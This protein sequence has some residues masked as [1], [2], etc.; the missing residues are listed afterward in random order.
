MFAFLSVAGNVSVKVAVHKSVCHRLLFL[1]KE[2]VTVGLLEVHA[3][4]KFWYY[5]QIAF[6]EF[7]SIRFPIIFFLIFADV[8]HRK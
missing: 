7:E 1:W 3:L 2:F 8:M 6:Q 5:C 4:L